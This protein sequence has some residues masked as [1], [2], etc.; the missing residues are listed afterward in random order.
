MCAERAERRGLWGQSFDYALQ[1]V[2]SLLRDLGLSL[3]EKRLLMDRLAHARRVEVN[4]DGA[5][6]HELG[7][8][9]RTARQRLEALI[10]PKSDCADMAARTAA[11]WRARSER[12]VPL[13]GHVRDR[14][15]AGAVTA[16]LSSLAASFVHMHA[17]RMFRSSV[18][19]HELVL[20]D[21]LHRLYDSALA[22]E[23]RS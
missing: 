18:R 2:D 1:G 10:E 7:A 13:A 14:V 11:L 19:L 20:Y 6:V 16:P 12:I 17:I 22:R 9:Y 21:H 15:A 4:A 8:K 23:K 5:L 3:P